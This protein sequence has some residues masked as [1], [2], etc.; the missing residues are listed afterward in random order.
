MPAQA[1]R[2]NAASYDAA[3]AAAL[4]RGSADALSELA[5]QLQIGEV[6]A[7][8]AIETARARAVE[9]AVATAEAQARLGLE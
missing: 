6:Q 2:N 7:R 4:R 9:E 1:K 3:V 8:E 5:G